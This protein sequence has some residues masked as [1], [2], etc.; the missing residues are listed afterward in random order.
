MILS[1]GNYGGYVIENDSAVLYDNGVAVDTQEAT[2]GD[3]ITIN[4]WVYNL[5]GIFIGIE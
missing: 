4:G 3:T 1:G 5:E 2:V